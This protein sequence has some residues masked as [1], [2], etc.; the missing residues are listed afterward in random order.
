[1]KSFDGFLESDHYCFHF[2][3][4]SLAVREISQIAEGQERCFREISNFLC[5]GFSMKFLT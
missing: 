4:G 3:K 5:V 2:H 1:M